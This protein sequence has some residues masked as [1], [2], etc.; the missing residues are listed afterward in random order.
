VGIVPGI[1]PQDKTG[2]DKELP[3]LGAWRAAQVTPAP[4]GRKRL[5]L[6]KAPIAGTGN[7]RFP[8]VN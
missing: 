7:R 6:R 5:V 8:R 2:R 3:G 1:R 4:I